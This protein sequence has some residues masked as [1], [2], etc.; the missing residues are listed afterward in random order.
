M[1]DTTQAIAAGLSGL[2]IALQALLVLLALVALLSLALKPLRRPLTALRA[3]LAG[4]EL[5]LAFVVAAVAVAGSLYFSEAAHFVPCRLCWFQRI[6][7]Y[8][9][10]PLL[11][12][13]ALFLRPARR[14]LAEARDTLLG[15]EL[16]IA[17]GIALLATLGSLYF[18]EVADFVP[19]RLCWFQRI[20]MYPL[21]VLLLVGA[22]RRD[23][24]GAV[25]YGLAFPVV[26]AGVA[27]YH[28]YI[29][30]NPGAESAGC[31][32]TAPCSTKWIDE[33][34]YVTIPTLALTAFATVFVLMLFALRR[35]SAED[36]EAAALREPLDPAL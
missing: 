6:A 8:P 22:V 10:V 11:L 35:T 29:E 12:I 20:A 1:S 18:S 5:W 32:A 9:L 17:W 28:I 19:C 14:V 27:I 31:R 30:N 4:G 23:V 2:A 21:A 7:M 25:L 36:R 13:A 24:R 34:G 26:G 33:F 16:W 3:S 15:G